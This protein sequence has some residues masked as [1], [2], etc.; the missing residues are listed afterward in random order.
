MTTCIA[1][2]AGATAVAA[3]VRSTWS[4]C[5][6]SM[7]S[8]ITP[9]SERSK[10]HSYRS[11]A[12]WFIVGAT[13]GGATVGAGMALV[14]LVV[15][16]IGPSPTQAGVIALLAAL[17]AAWSD[18][19]IW[20]VHLPIHRRQVNERWLDQYRAWV[21]G[22]GF[23]WQ[24]GT[25]LFTYI[26]TA[27]V[28]LMIVLG[29][30]TGSPVV[31]LV[32]GTGFGFLR[33]LAVLLTRNLV[34]PADLLAFYRRLIEVGPVV[35]RA[36]IGIEL[37][38]ALAVAAWLRAPWAVGVA[39]SA[40]LVALLLPSYRRHRGL[41]AGGSCPVPSTGVNADRAP[42]SGAPPVRQGTDELVAR[43]A[44]GYTG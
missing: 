31:A 37:A 5:G 13:T 20:G 19:D 44:D 28:Y 10:G 12:T 25:G 11:T 1:L 33:G 7:L 15:R 40:T 36:V 34:R 39:G 41:V 8:T 18:A 35:G 21:Y 16:G 27:A 23:G 29:S 43:V 4:P 6:L 26:T 32:V 14:A 30:L 9:V 3:A 38:S 22:A 42:G 24:I 2:L 17:V